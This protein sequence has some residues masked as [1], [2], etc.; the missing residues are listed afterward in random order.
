MS[1]VFGHD[2]R[3]K[4]GGESRQKAGG[5]GGADGAPALILVL[6]LAGLV[7]LYPQIQAAIQASAH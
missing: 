1:H 5:A 3:L 7:A 2:E 6:L 4:G